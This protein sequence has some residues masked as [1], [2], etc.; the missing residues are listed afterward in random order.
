MIRQPPRS[1]LVPY[2]TL[3]R[4]T[5]TAQAAAAI[6]HRETLIELTAE[7]AAVAK[8]EATCDTPVGLCARHLDGT[9]AVAGFAGDRKSTRL[10]SSH[11]NISYVVFSLIKIRSAY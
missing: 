11:A 9:L 2:R 5:E 8:L 3:F 1:T 10:N 7:R 4:S 6:T